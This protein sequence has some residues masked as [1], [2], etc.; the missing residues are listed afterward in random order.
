MAKV[1][2]RYRSNMSVDIDATS[3][4]TVSICEFAVGFDRF[5]RKTAVHGSVSVFTVPDFNHAQSKH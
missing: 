2:Y 3:A 1:L 5:L 4:V